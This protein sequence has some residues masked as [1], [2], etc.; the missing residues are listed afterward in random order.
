M[1]V[2]EPGYLSVFDLFGAAPRPGRGAGEF[3]PLRPHGLPHP[4]PAPI[5][6]RG[7]QCTTAHVYE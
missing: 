4:A 6:P 1:G 3:R 2:S 5:P 7:W